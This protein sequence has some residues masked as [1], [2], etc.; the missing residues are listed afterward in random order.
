MNTQTITATVKELEALTGYNQAT[1]SILLR[2]AQDNGK[3]R[4]IGSVVKP[5]DVTTE[6]KAIKARG[7]PAS[8]WEVEPFTVDLTKE[9][10]P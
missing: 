9:A 3:A 7:K 2:L 5:D 1:L 6:G 8:I 4:I 10:N